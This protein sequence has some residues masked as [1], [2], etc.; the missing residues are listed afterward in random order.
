MTDAAD[1]PMASYELPVLLLLTL[2]A[3]IEE[4]HARLAAA[5]FADVRPAHFFA[6]QFIGADGTTGSELA[7]H[8]GTTKQAAQQMLDY[9]EEH[10]YIRRQ[11][12]PTDRRGKLVTLDRRGW[13][14]LA[15]SG[16]VFREIEARWCAL[17]GDA[18]VSLVRGALARFVQD[19]DA[20]GI[21]P[22]LRPIW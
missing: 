6:F 9:L 18:A 19:A 3:M 17:T 13:D 5:G 1:N 21:A 22:R 20:R 4:S 8:L 11:P 7:A 14:A 16:E 15:F 10:G 12:H 2:G